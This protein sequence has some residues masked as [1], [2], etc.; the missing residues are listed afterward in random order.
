MD[1]SSAGLN[2]IDSLMLRYVDEKKLPGMVIMVARHGKIVKFEKYGLMDVDKPMDL[3]A[4]F[5]IASMTKPI[6]SVAAMILYDEGYFQLDDPVAKY[7]PEFQDLK[8]FS[9]KDKNGIHVEEQKTPMTIRNLLTHTSG[10]S[11]GMEDSPVDSLYRVAD[12]SNAF[13][14]KDLIQKLAK[15]PLKYQPGTR[16]QYGESTDVLGYLV[17]V[18]SGKSLDLF[19]KERIFK[20]LKMVETDYFVPNEKI[21]LVSKVYAIGQHGMEMIKNPEVNNLSKSVKSI[22]GNGGL[23]STASDYMIFSQMILNKGVYN[24]VRILKSNTVDLMTS[25]QLSHVIMPDD[26]FM[27]KIMLG[28]G[29]GFGFAILQDEIKAN[30]IGTPGSYWWSGSANTYFYIDP[31]EELVLILMTQFVPNFHYPVFKEFRE[32]VYKS[33]ES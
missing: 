1:I 21:S 20:P 19:F 22:R 32:L 11:S 6:T 9:Y 4:I 25:N 13:T 27:G 10:F 33:I 18:L 7:V 29:F 12:L 24:G 30:T 26:D 23:L 16:W 2:K 14:L 17:E 3:N 31:K 28:M 8:V 15:I 5:R